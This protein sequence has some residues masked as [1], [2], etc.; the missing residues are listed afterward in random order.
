MCRARMQ[1]AIVRTFIGTNHTTAQ[2][3][4]C[5]CGRTKIGPSVSRKAKTRLVLRMIGPGWQKPS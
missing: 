4:T 3:K 2:S 5:S 1:C